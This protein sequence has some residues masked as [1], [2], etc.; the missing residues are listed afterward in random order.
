MAL[1][2]PTKCCCFQIK[3]L[4]F[5]V[6][7]LEI[8][9][10]YLWV[11]DWRNVQLWTFLVLNAVIVYWS[12]CGF[13]SFFNFESVSYDK[14]SQIVGQFNFGS[15]AFLSAFWLNGNKSYQKSYGVPLKVCGPSSKKV[16]ACLPPLV[17][18]KS[19]IR[20]YLCLYT[21]YPNAKPHTHAHL[22]LASWCPFIRR[23]PFLLN[24]RNFL[25][26]SS[27][28][29]CKSSSPSLSYVR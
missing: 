28:F 26:A 16:R 8:R 21:L 25:P 18:S 24:G 22:P 4:E 23:V 29:R 2:C 14:N 13:R 7:N 9:E 20:Q 1:S 6:C 5:S 17:C 3:C 10:G 15:R 12:L 11:T 19:S 27:F